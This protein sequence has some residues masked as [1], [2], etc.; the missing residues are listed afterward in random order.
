MA[1]YSNR[2]RPVSQ[3]DKSDVAAVVRR[4]ERPAYQSADRAYAL[5]VLA[6]AEIE[7]HRTAQAERLIEEAFSLYDQWN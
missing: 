7:N 2:T 1:C 3:A 5:I 4:R 6:Q